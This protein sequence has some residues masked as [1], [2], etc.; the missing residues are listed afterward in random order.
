MTAELKQIVANRIDALA[1]QLLARVARHPRA[2][3][4]RL[5]RTPREWLA[6][7]HAR[8]PPVL[9]V[10]RSVYG[11][12]TAFES[13]FA[14]GSFVGNRGSARGAARRIRCAARHRPRVRPQSDCDLR[15][16]RHARPRGNPRPALRHG[17]A[18]GNPRRRERRRQGTDGARRCFRRCRRGDDDPSVRH[19][20]DHDAVHLRR[21]SAR[22]VSRPRGAR[23]RDA[24]PRH[25]RARRICCSRIRPSRTCASTF[26]RPSAFTASS[27]T[28][29][30]HRT[31]FRTLP[32]A[33]STYAPPTSKIW[34]G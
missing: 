31:S 10:K 33:T 9:P 34:R 18:V 14:G 29:A 32:P 1:E 26:R 4:A 22:R 23:V 8:R 27:P 11:L 15:S 17:A 30:S 28:A 3:G 19:Q 6:V 25:Q 21:R 5:Q 20:P 12:E 16:R 13:E 7:R 24:A 2:S